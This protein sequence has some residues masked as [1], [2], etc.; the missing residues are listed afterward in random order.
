MYTCTRIQIFKD[1]F[2]VEIHQTTKYLKLYVLKFQTFVGAFVGIWAGRND[3]RF[4]DTIKV[5]D[6]P[7]DED[8]TIEGNIKVFLIKTHYFK[9]LRK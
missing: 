2:L 1:L 6:P 3:E 5:T 7:G 4:N 8:L 9:L